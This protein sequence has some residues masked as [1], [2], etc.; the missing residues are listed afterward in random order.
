[1]GSSAPST[2]TQI[3]KTELPE[4]LNRA[5]ERNIQIAD[6]ISQRPYQAYGGSTVAGLTPDQ[7]A[8]FD[9]ARSGIGMT[10]MPFNLAQ[11]AA[12]NAAFYR[13]DQVQAQTF[14]GQALAPYMNPYLAEVEN[15]AVDAANRSLLTNLNTISDNAARAGAFG[16]S[17]QGLAEGVATAETAR[18]VGDLSANLRAQGFNTA[19]S[20]FQSD[21]ARALEAA[22][23]NQAAGLQGAGLNA[24]AA[25]TL[26]SLATNAQGAR[27]MD[28]ATLQAIG[29]QQQA[30]D[31]RMLDDAY[32][33]FLEQRNYPIEMLN[34]RLGATSATPY[35]QTQTTTRTGGP[36]GN[37]TLQTV[38]TGLSALAS[39]ASIAS[40]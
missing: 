14:S 16:G 13:P 25:S 1:M 17:R 23:A 4:W 18:N 2:T 34:L 15:R 29:E 33:R 5:S 10:A 24:Q 20:L 8:S 27:A 40:F 32:A 31:Q 28:I 36:Q 35:S 3:T 22:R 39:L 9:Y 38:G 7:T 12:A 37:S 21:Q 19:A 26:G 11:G 6:E 30:Q